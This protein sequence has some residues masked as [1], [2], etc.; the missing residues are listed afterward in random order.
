M[1]ETKDIK[2]FSSLRTGLCFLAAILVSFWF[3][4]F[5]RSHLSTLSFIWFPLPAQWKPNS[6]QGVSWDRDSTIKM[7]EDCR[8]SENKIKVA[9][10]TLQFIE[11]ILANPLDT[12]SSEIDSYNRHGVSQVQQDFRDV[13]LRKTLATFEVLFYKERILNNVKLCNSCSK[14]N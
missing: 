11:Y 9:K 5:K 12:F 2:C 6:S 7:L 1:N 8:L 14:R 4:W 10:L 13:P 3:R